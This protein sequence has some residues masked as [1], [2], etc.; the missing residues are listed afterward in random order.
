MHVH[1]CRQRLRRM[2]V[3][4][5]LLSRLNQRASDAV[6]ICSTRCE[7]SVQLGIHTSKAKNPEKVEMLVKSLEDALQTKAPEGDAKQ[8]WDHLRDTIHG[9]AFSVFGRKQGRT[10]DR[11]DATAVN[12][13]QASAMPKICLADLVKGQKFV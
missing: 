5:V 12:T 13:V 10:Q 11:I 7:C 6:L 4:F 2:L 3:F 8:R 9:T 1:M